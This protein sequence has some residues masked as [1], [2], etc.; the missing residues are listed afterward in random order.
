MRI[1]RPTGRRVLWGLVALHLVAGV[2]LA[3]WLG[4]WAG[5]LPIPGTG[6]DASQGEAALEALGMYGEVP[7]FAFTDRG[8]RVVTRRDLLGTVWI[9]NFIYTQCPET[10][11]VQT[12]ELARLQAE[13]PAEPDLRLVSITVD[14][15]RDTPAALA[16]YAERHGADPA[17]WLFLTGDKRAIYRLAKEGFRLGVVD[18]HDGGAETGLSPPVLSPRAAWAAHGSTGLI[19]HSARLVLVDRQA[20]I[21]AYHLAN[22]PPSLERLRRNLTRV[23]GEGRSG[24][25]AP[26]GGS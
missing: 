20:R 13:F 10:C 25:P 12:A 11:P 15:E 24:P 1:P 9:A 22:D 23:L 14:P 19:M 8:G 4:H 5:V 2:G 6:S 17:R 3:A 21:R 16:A 26:G 7:D 18:P